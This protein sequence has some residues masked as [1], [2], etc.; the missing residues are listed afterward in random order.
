MPA[1]RLAGMARPERYDVP[2]FAA[3]PVAK[4]GLG[5]NAQT[6]VAD[7]TSASPAS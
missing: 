7:K 3:L 2:T 5:L 1:E 4:R 6:F